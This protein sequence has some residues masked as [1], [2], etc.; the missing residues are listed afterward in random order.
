MQCIPSRADDVNLAW[1]S[2]AT[3]MKKPDLAV[4]F[5]FCAIGLLV[6]L[7]ALFRFPEFAAIIANSGPIW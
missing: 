1:S 6:T 7:D 5:A 4:V 3:A 2:L